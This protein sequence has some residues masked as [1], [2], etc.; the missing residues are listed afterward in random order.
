MD[1]I[2]KG[3]GGFYYVRTAAGIIECKAR[4]NFRNKKIQPF[5]GDYVKISINDRAENTIDE[6]LPRKNSLI[7][8]AVANIDN[9]IILSS[10]VTPAPSTLVID[11][12][13]AVCEKKGIEPIILFNKT[14]I[15]NAD[16]FVEI[17]SEAGF[18]SF[19]VSAKSG[20]GTDRIKELFAGKTTVFTGN[21]GV[22]KS[23]VMNRIDERL[24]LETG[25]VSEKLGRG[26]HT[27]RR[28]EIFEM[29][30]GE[31]VDTPGFSS[32]DIEKFETI[33]KDDL[34]FCFREFE[35]FT[36]ECRFNS[37]SHI[38]EEGCAVKAAVESGKI[39]LSRYESYKNMYEEVKNIREWEI[40]R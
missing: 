38:K 15:K 39:P 29:Y 28:C 7:R 16:E 34:Q 33:L 13:T 27:T 8:P 2:I 36:G 5:V 4:G 18:T 24:S 31:V 11:K 9:L 17:Y 6:I 40:N 12:L 20:E 26:R 25:E 32:V 23:S 14:D 19:S 21:S 22:G 1:R 10:T 37:C 30:S 3:I 35:P